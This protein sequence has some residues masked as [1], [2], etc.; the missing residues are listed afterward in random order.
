MNNV[1]PMNSSMLEQAHTYTD[2]SGLNALKAQARTDKSAALKEVAK[3]FESLFMSMMLKSMR[4]A[5]KPFAEGNFMNSSQS[6][7]YQEM[8]DSQLTL[9]M[10]KGKG[11]GLAD[12]LYRQLSQE[13]GVAEGREP[14]AQGRYTSIQ[15]YP[16][17]MPPSVQRFV[18]AVVEVDEL[19]EADMAK[20]QAVVAGGAAAE[21]TV[22][23]PALAES[24]KQ[25]M[26]TSFTSADEFVST[27]YP[28]AKSIEQETGIDARFLLAQSA[29]ETGWGKHMIANS[30]EKP[31][32][33]LFGIKADARWPGASVDITTT[34]Y[35][36]G[37]PM[38]EKAAFRAYP[39]YEESF[40]DY[41]D[42]IKTNSRYSEAVEV[43]QDPEQFIEQLHKAGYATDPAYSEKVQRIFNSDLLQSALTNSQG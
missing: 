24:E 1:S 28:M 36:E 29:L 26:P 30:G 4:D 8:F 19:I 40:R 7:F 15:D 33:N 32:F 39:S 16:R 37:R 41:V 11:M 42:F 35:R 22:D 17:T 25:S 5:N 23:L 43:M 9:S 34:E 38:K 12:S 31:S 13:T 21:N 10:S 18:E 14:G 3:Q 20:T 6:E 27:L 2:F